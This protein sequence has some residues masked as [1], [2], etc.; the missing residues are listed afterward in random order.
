MALSIRLATPEDL[1][2]VLRLYLKAGLDRG[3]TVTPAEAEQWFRTLQH[4][5]SYHLWVAYEGDIL[6][7]TFTLLI[8]DNLNHHGCPSGVVEGVGVDPTYQGQGI[9]RQMMAKAIALCWEAGCYKMTLSTNLNRT[10]AHAF[11]ESLGFEKH[12]Y[13]YRIELDT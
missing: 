1:P 9:G 5:P 12:G 8:M 3:D 11:Y 13:S 6:V 10:Q 7:G 2:A 4:Y